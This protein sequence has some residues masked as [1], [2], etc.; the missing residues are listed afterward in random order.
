MCNYSDYNRKMFKIISNNTCDG[1]IIVDD[2]NL[3]CFVNK[4]IE[5]VLGVCSGFSVNKYMV[6]RRIMKLEGDN[7]Y[8]IARRY[9][10]LKVYK[11]DNYKMILLTDISWKKK[12]TRE[13]DILKR[14]SEDFKSLIEQFGDSS[15]YITDNKG[16]TT[17]VGSGVAEECGTTKEALIGRSVYEL[18]AEK[19]F[20]PS[21][22]AIA[23]R[24]LQRE[25]IIQTSATGKKVIAMA[26][27]LFDKNNKLMKVISFSKRYKMDNIKTL[28]D[29][30]DNSNYAKDKYYPY[31]ISKATSMI[32]V[33]NLIDL[34]SKVDS[35]VIIYGEKGSGKKN[36]A[37][38]IHNMSNRFGKNFIYLD[39][40]NILSAKYEEVWGQGGVMERAI[41]GTI[42]ITNILEADE[43]WLDYILQIVQRRGFEQDIRVI[44]GCEK[45]SKVLRND[46]LK[47]ILYYFQ[48]L[49]I[50]CPPLRTRKEDIFMLAKYFL[51]EMNNKF[52]IDNQLSALALKNL[53]DYNWPGNVEELKKVINLLCKNANSSII[54]Q[55]NL[56]ENIRECYTEDLLLKRNIKVQPLKDTVEQLEKYIIKN[57]L[58]R[59]DFNASIAAKELGLTQSTMSRKMQK[60]NITNE[61][62]D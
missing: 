53:Y 7:E 4:Y 38:L 43:V 58:K 54:E 11:Y 15:L 34:C 56:P 37:K 32:E 31:I 29:V 5:K 45:N 23:I 52:N 49:Q 14:E 20:Y 1:I 22:I 8:I 17:W 2:K 55:H 47:K 61:K 36:I 25:I 62:G 18:E 41:G 30:I 24:S 13:I 27:P 12:L 59:N 3:I 21:A 16:I 26:F 35:P 51:N 9:Y 60:Y 19:V 50:N 33:K 42:Y 28:E 44:I 40:K 57:S 6:I 46:K 48:F 10:Y 39:F